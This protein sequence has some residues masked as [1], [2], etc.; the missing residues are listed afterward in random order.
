MYLPN[1]FSDE[2]VLSL[3]IYLFLA[4]I[5]LHNIYQ[6]LLLLDLWL[7]SGPWF[8][9]TMMCNGFL[10]LTA[11]CQNNLYILNVF[12]VAIYEICTE[13]NVNALLIARLSTTCSWWSFVIA[14][15]MV[16]IVNK[17]FVVKTW[18]GC[19]YCPL[20]HIFMKLG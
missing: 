16:C 14:L 4:L 13:L 9:D 17:C 7:K 18:R 8:V 6:L 5:L 12:V 10:Y 11:Y 20:L 15:C 3:Q 19:I 2:F 1:I